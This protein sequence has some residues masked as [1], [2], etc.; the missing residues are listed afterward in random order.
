[1]QIRQKFLSKGH[2]DNALRVAVQSGMDPVWAVIAATLNS[3]ECYRLY[4]KGAIA[5]GFDADVAVYD[6]LKDF[7]CAF[8]FK[9]GKLVAKEGKALFDAEAEGSDVFRI[10]AAAAGEAEILLPGGEG[11]ELYALD[12]AGNRLEH[13]ALSPHGNRTA[14]RLRVFNP[15]GQTMLY[16]LTR[17]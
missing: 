2:L 15:F 13:V 12:T 9:A 5:P 17:K 4:G 16:E 11:V 8:V 1:M 7:N 14:A 3:A 10:N 6:D